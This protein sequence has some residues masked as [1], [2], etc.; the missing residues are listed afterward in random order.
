MSELIGTFGGLVAFLSLGLY[1]DHQMKQI[2]A[3]LQ[4]KEDD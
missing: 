3:E 4:H 1:L 2:N